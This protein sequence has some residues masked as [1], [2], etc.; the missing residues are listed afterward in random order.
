MH[1]AYKRIL[2]MHF[3]ESYLELPEEWLT[4]AQMWPELPDP[5]GSSDTQ[6]NFWHDSAGEQKQL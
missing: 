4:S 3:G 1:S 5:S 2:I 6:Q